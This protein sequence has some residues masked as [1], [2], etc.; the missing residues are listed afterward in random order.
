MLK[1]ISSNC[2]REHY[3]RETGLYKLYIVTNTDHS[4]FYYVLFIMR[5][6]LYSKFIKL[7]IFTDNLRTDKLRTIFQASNIADYKE[8]LAIINEK[9]NFIFE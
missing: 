7:Y 4:D 5:N 9:L 2:F 8:L 1:V 6:I 3:I